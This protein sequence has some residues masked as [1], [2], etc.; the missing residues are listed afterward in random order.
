M[1]AGLKFGFK[2]SSV[3]LR[4]RRDIMAGKPTIIWTIGHSNRTI[5]DFLDLL[6]AY[7]IQ[8]LADVRRFPGSRRF[9]QF[10]QEEF[11]GSLKQAGI[12]YVH[13]PELGG[14]RP[15]QPDSPNSNWRNA[16]FRGYADYM[17]S[18]E[19]RSGIERLLAIARKQ[20][21]A[22]MCAEALWWQCHRALISDFLKIRSWTMLHILG[23]NKTQEHPFTSAA[24]IVNDKLSYAPP[25]SQPEFRGL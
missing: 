5:E 20:R 14:R 24:R 16:A 4:G 17:L 8:A 15:V 18:A 9:P 1:G 13:F 21:T 12:S 23:A 25:L 19:F 6:R 10:G 3:T 11:S 2:K 22:I 7:H